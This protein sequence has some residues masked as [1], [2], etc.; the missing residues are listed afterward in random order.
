MNSNV[1]ELLMRIMILLVLSAS[2]SVV[3]SLNA[4]EQIRANRP[5]E[6]LGFSFRG[7]WSATFHSPSFSALPGTVDCGTYNTGK[8]SA[9]GTALTVEYPI[10]DRFHVGLAATFLSR[11]GRLLTPNDSEP[12]FD[13]TT[14]SVVNVITENALNVR[15]GYLEIA[16]TLWWAPFTFGR[17]TIR[18]NA[19][20]RFGFPFT[21]QMQQL[22]RILSPD[23]AVFISNQR[24]TID[25]TDGYRTLTQ[26]RQPTIGAHIGI[27][28]LLPIGSR[29]EL[30]QQ[31]AYD[32]MFTSPIRD[33]RWAMQGFR[34]ELGI[35]MILERSPQQQNT[36]PTPV[37][38]DTPLIVTTIAPL[39]TPRLQ[40]SI[41]SFEGHLE[42]GTEL[43]AT[44]PL[45]NAVF[46]EAG[47]AVIPKR[48]SLRSADSIKTT[49]P[50]IAHRNVLLVVADL[51][52]RN[53]GATVIC[54]G[55]TSGDYEHGDTSLA[56]R[57]AE[58]VAQALESV[59]VER[60][61]IRTRWSLLPRAASN[62]DYPEGRAE[63]Q[64]VDITLVN[65][66]LVEYVSKQTFAALV[67]NLIVHVGGTAIDGASLELRATGAKPVQGLDTGMHRLPVQLRL[68]PATQNIAIEARSIIP[69]THIESRDTITIA[70]DTLERRRV[71][72]S[73]ARFE[74]VLRFEYNS[75]QLSQENRELLRQLVE[76]IPEGAT[77]EIGG[78]ADV[79]GDVAR[80]RRLAEDRARVTE[81]YLRSLSAG[82]RIRI[83]ARGIERQFTDV[84][85]EGRF[86]NRSIRITLP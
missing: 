74:A 15:L 26:L 59:G 20:V 52:R 11:G 25:W 19:G 56:R 67:G 69:D 84:L 10:G 73:T 83:V 79:L 48:Y 53:P 54:E 58:A 45:V 14:G 31:L 42:E 65:A 6:L 27:E 9:L 50:V 5:A 55:A 64:R 1:K 39:E 80:N 24:R 33:V 43:I 66:P 29:L 17:S 72:L 46:F 28:H 34:A 81:D 2:V 61:R 85:P 77:V 57:R 32:N 13:S 7:I 62:M 8:G 36:L 71:E 37:V 41:R 21:A 60:T 3:P 86:L 40:L 12:A 35:R 4:Q 78:S 75:S 44:L 16:P 47:S 82:K 70:L 68:D 30:V 76:R 51:L 22:R 63:N 23:N 18:V 49:D 38:V